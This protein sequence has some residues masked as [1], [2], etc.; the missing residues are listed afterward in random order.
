MENAVAV[1]EVRIQADGDVIGKLKGAQSEYP[2]SPGNPILLIS[3][4]PWTT[5]AFPLL[6]GSLQPK[7]HRCLRKRE[8]TQPFCFYSMLFTAPLRFGLS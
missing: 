1:D 6:N 5:S 8:Y 7:M 4:Y 3:G 2:T